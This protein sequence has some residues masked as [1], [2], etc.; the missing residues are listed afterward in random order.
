MLTENVTSYQEQFAPVMSV[1]TSFF[2]QGLITQL[3]KQNDH[4]LWLFDFQL[5]NS[6]EKTFV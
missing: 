3:S 1:F 4:K 2:P 5:N 6:N